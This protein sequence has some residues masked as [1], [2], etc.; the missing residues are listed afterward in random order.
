MLICGTADFSGDGD[1]LVK[2][3][4]GR[5]VSAPAREGDEGILVVTDDS[6]RSESSHSSLNLFESLIPRDVPSAQMN[7]RTEKLQADRPPGSRD[8]RSDPGA[9]REPPNWHHSFN[10]AGHASSL[11]SGRA[12]LRPILGSQRGGQSAFLLVP[13][14]CLIQNLDSPP[15]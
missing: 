15:L 12:A 5:S 3:H 14:S 9:F 6:L 8:R 1:H 4:A 7:T 10:S 11:S 13:V 2:T